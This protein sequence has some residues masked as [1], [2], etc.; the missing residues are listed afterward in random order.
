MIKRLWCYIQTMFPVH[1]AVVVCLLSFGVCWCTAVTVAGAELAFHPRLIAGLLSFTLFFLLLRVMDEFKD[2]DL[3]CRLFPDRPLVTGM[4]TRTDLTVLGWSIAV[5]LFLLNVGQGILVFSM[6]LVCFV[7]TLLMFK[8][9]FWQKVREHL[10]FALVTHN[11]VAFLFQCY[12]ISYY[13]QH[14]Q[15]PTNVVRLLP[16]A[17]LF[18]LPWLAWEI[19]RKIRAVASEDAYETYSQVFGYRRACG[20]VIALGI[21]IF[22]GAVWVSRFYTGGLVLIAGMGAATAFLVYRCLRFAL[23]PS[24]GKAPLRP[25]LETYM[26]LFFV[27]FTAVQFFR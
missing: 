24:P 1:R 7:Y 23:A 26:L 18:W 5:A 17:F 13:V 16:V 15:E 9:F 6:Y 20:I 27:T 3:D 2:Y 14:A 12:V 21:L 4:V 8:F 10:V 25:V 19:A 11:P 22:A